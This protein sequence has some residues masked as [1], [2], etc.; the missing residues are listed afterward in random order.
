MTSRRGRNQTGL[1]VTFTSDPPPSARSLHRLNRP[2]ALLNSSQ[3]KRPFHGHICNMVFGQARN[4]PNHEMLQQ[5]DEECEI[6][7]I[8]FLTE[9]NP[10]FVYD[11]HALQQAS[12][13]MIL[14][15]ALLAA[16]WLCSEAGAYSELKNH[17]SR[18]L[19]EVNPN[20]VYDYVVVGSGAGGATVAA[21]LAQS[22]HSVI[23]VE[24]GEDLTKTYEFM[25]PGLSLRA[26]EYPPMTWEF[27][28]NHYPTLELQRRDSKMT[29]VTPS[30]QRYVGLSPPPGS[31]PLGVLYPRASTFGGC[32]GHNALVTVY[33]EESDWDDIAKMTGDQSWTAP[34][35]R[36]YF[37]SL[38]R[39]RYVPHSLV[40]HGFRGW[41]T[42]SVA[43]ILFFLQD[44]KLLA[45]LHGAASALGQ[46]F[47]KVFENIEGL[48]NVL[49]R[50][51]NSGYPNRDRRE[52]L[53][54]IPISTKNGVRSGP[55]GLFKDVMDAT[56]DSG[57][58][59][60]GGGSRYH[61]D[62]LLSSLVT[63]IVLQPPT[64]AG[65]QARAVG[66]E[67]IQGKNLYRA[68]PLSKPYAVPPPV[69]WLRAG[70]E[71]IV[72]AGAFNTPQ[73]M[74]LSGLGPRRELERFGIPV[75]VDLPGVGV[76]LQDR[77]EVSV[78]SSSPQSFFLTKHCT[79]LTKTPDP[80]LI[81]WQ[82]GL[83][84]AGKGAYTSAGLAFAVLKKSSVAQSDVPDLFIAGALANFT[85]YFLGY[86]QLA[87]EG[88]KHWSWIILKAHTRNRAG[89]VELRS[90]DPRDTPIIN[91]NY[92]QT[93]TNNQGQAEKD[94]VALSEGV[95]WARAATANVNNYLY[96]DRF[97][98]DLPGESVVGSDRETQWAKDE[99]WG[100]H[101]SCTCAIG[102]ADDPYAVL[103]SNFRVRGVDG[104]RIVD[105]SVFPFI[106]G[107][108][109][110]LSI[111]MIAE[112]AAAVIHEA[113]AGR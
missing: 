68:D 94:A 34:R 89:T 33:P 15:T 24:A 25:T 22:G 31:R 56:N 95:R 91:F 54:Q 75:I 43:S 47:A 2:M 72:S 100:H 97:T 51:L 55:T 52:G 84:D 65:Y 41:L 50:D 42:T 113:A 13:I 27:F 6:G 104:L 87:T 86:D 62:I 49:H 71:V 112:K 14:V 38:E 30:G 107:Y 20:F 11:Y 40:G 46:G 23:V 59:G 58:G 48:V 53:F 45:M 85:G 70:R 8:R 79:F 10:N 16:F 109:I 99:A 80:C 7:L 64:R 77:Y 9:V 78:T 21:R 61:L 108:Y 69:R 82:N 101:A 3:V 67:Y 81:R 44:P 12:P 92:F 111:Y 88:H 73:L 63:K 60:G 57:G 26:S 35:M 105:A 93:G 83:T 29:Y 76:N 66:V 19:T 96:F 103:D 4:A 28:V 17:F 90:T 1:P 37:E 36:K 5:L 74:K 106:P 110:A 102:A 39:C 32:T 98:E 18:F